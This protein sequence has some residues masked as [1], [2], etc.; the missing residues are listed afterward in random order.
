MTVAKPTRSRL[1]ALGPPQHHPAAADGD[2]K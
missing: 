1:R 2:T